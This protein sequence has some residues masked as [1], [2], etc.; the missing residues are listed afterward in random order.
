MNSD[1]QE[2]RDKQKASWNR[3]S[4]GWKKWNK[5]LLQHMQPA[6]DGIIE[7][8]QPNGNQK[9]LDIASGAGEPAFSIAK[10]LNGGEVILTDLADDMLSIARENAQA[11]G[12][13]NVS[14][15]A[16]DVCE[17]PFAENSFDHVSCR[18]GFMFFPDLHIAAKEINRVLKPGGRFATTVWSTPD[19][20]FW[21]TIISDV[22]RKNLQL[23]DTT[24]SQEKPGIFRCA[25][26]GFMQTVLAQAGFKN[27]HV[28]EI[29]CLLH[30]GTAERY[31]QMMTEIAA[32]VVGV[33]NK[34]DDIMKEKIKQ[35]VISLLN[36][37]YPEGNI[38]LPGSAILLHG[39]K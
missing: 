4:S 6:T 18:M 11:T 37:K 12:I 26:Q 35:E 39:E 33:L 1:I 29:N 22:I 25:E 21:I 31:W 36:A 14:F 30:C 38:T 19:K 10:K 13:K 23:P 34:I 3:F 9:I 24:P 28:K 15:R 16:C 20:N 8:L 7:F 32:P 2:I 17:L 27:I 5:E